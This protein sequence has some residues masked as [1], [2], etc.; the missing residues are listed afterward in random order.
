MDEMRFELPFKTMDFDQLAQ[1]LSAILQVPLY[2]NHSPM[3]GPWYSSVDLGAVSAAIRAGDLE[4][5]KRLAERLEK[6]P[7]LPSLT[8]T[9]D[10]DDYRCGGPDLCILELKTTGPAQS[11]EI[12]ETLQRSLPA[13]RR[14]GT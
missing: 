14:T 1:L 8:L 3:C 10:D 13:L 5:V 11:R 6:E 12:E 2:K 9:T 7:R 4:T